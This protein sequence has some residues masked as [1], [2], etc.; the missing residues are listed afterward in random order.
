MKQVEP[1]EL[2]S[3]NATWYLK[4]Q[5]PKMHRKTAQ[6]CKQEGSWLDW[7]T[8]K[9]EQKKN[10]SIGAKE[11][12]RIIANIIKQVQQPRTVTGSDELQFCIIG[13][14]YLITYFVIYCPLA[15]M[16]FLYFYKQA[17]LHTVVGKYKYL[18]MRE[19]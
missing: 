11:Q 19:I 10:N 13:I 2:K 17:Q 5:E 4:N 15:I 1:K 16:Y 18:A 8:E 12:F 14:L 9:Y 7:A 6:A 3:H